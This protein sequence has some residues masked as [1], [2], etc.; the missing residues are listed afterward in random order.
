MMQS[1]ESNIIQAQSGSTRPLES[2]DDII[3]GKA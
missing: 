1:N 3:V 2:S